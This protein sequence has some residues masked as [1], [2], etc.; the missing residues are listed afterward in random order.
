MSGEPTE[1]TD[2]TADSTPEP[3]GPETAEPAGPETVEPAGP[4]T[5]ET[6]S[7]PS[8]EP[9]ATEQPPHDP[10]APDAPNI[11]LEPA[12]WAGREWVVN[13]LERAGLPTNDLDPDASRDDAPAL[14][15][16]VGPP[17]RVGCIGVERY[18]DV[19]LLRSA[20]VVESERGQGYGAAAVRELEAAARDAGVSEL[21]LLTTTAE[22][23]FTDLGYE[24]VDRESI[25]SALDASAEVSDLCPDSAT[26]MRRSL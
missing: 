3:T 2:P 19:G 9:S 18:G 7:Q 13:L 24:A 1:S 25:P 4:G 23:F 26:V 21:Y 16:V 20:V 14:Y 6:T 11:R 5:T 15:V 10:A 8:A 22:R 17:G 12:T